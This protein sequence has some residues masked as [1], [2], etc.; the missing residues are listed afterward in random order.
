MPSR[1]DKIENFE[2]SSNTV[3]QIKYVWFFNK[4]GK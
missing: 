4:T 3:D 1:V 2:G